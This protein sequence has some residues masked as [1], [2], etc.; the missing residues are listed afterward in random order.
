MTL[1]QAIV[2]GLPFLLLALFIFWCICEVK[3]RQLRFRLF[4]GISLFLLTIFY[5]VCVASYQAL[6]QQSMQRLSLVQIFRVLQEIDEA[7]LRNAFAQIESDLIVG[8]LKSV[9]SVRK[10]LNRLATEEAIVGKDVD[11]VPKP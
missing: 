3:N 6:G 9:S 1:L 10:E 4:V 2:Y 5:F 7:D 11:E 8:E